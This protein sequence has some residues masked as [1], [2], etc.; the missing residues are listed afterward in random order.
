M[1][2]AFGRHELLGERQRAWIAEALSANG[3]VRN[4]ANSGSA[5]L[6]FSIRLS[7]C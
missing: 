5:W 2:A 7:C 1:R 4:V 3:E 6:A